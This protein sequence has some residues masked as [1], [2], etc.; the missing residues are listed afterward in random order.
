MTAFIWEHCSQPGD[1]YALSLSD[2]D[3]A[4]VDELRGLFETVR[5]SMGGRRRRFSRKA[6][7]LFERWLKDPSQPLPSR[8]YALLSNWF[9]NRAKVDRESPL[10][11]A[12]GDLWDAMFAVRPSDRL[13]PV[14]KNHQILEERF[15]L[16]WN[17]M[18]KKQGE[19]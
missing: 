8:A 6:T 14:E 2:P 16:W 3:R 11:D 9:L 1:A 5:R 12:C 18:A 4:D 19:E 17:D 7:A 15:A 13:T 10:G